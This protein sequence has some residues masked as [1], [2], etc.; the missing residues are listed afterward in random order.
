MRSRLLWKLEIL[1]T[2]GSY[3]TYSETPIGQWFSD[4][5]GW[6][7]NHYDRV[8]HLSF[9]LLVWRPLIELTFAKTTG[10]KRGW[11]DF[12]GVAEVA[13]FSVVYEIV[14][15]LATAVVDPS[16]GVAFLGAQG[17]IWDAQKDMGLACCGAVIAALL[18]RCRR[19]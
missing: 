14:E 7:R 15:W 18:A 6:E 4:A 3:Y 17:D 2:I 5:F 16:A 9:G 1:H 19:L 12:L 13:F 8:V 10:M 11:K